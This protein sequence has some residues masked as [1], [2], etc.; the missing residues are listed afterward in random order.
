MAI[1]VL[2]SLAAVAFL[3]YQNQQLKT[4][5]ASY[6]SNNQPSG[7]EAL[8]AGGQSPSPT[9]DVTANWK[10]YTNS[11]MGFG[12][13]LPSNW[14]SH[15]ETKTLFGYETNISFPVDNPSGQD[16]AK[17]QTANI[18]IGLTIN[19][20]KSLEALVQ[21]KINM[22]SSYLL[23]NPR[24]ILLDGEKATVLDF[25]SQD[26][27][28]VLVVH[29]SNYYS[30]SL[31]NPGKKPEI[32]LAFDQILSTFKFLSPASSPSVTPTY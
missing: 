26:G 20:Q 7:P 21:E 29:N 3:Y 16:F 32:N 13:K 28:D 9:P 23:N 17:N 1:F 31:D 11:V 22:P 10:T 30:I 24:E 8:R 14:F 25:K 6:Q 2:L 15:K 4:L 5:L 27:E 12:V 18:S 19:N